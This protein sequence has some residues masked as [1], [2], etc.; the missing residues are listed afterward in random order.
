MK[1]TRSSAFCLFALF[2]SDAASVAAQP[3]RSA[4]TVMCSASAY[5]ND[6]DPKGTHVRSGADSKSAVVATIR[7]PDSQLDITGSSGDWLR[8]KN[9][10]S[11]DGTVSFKGEGWMFAS[12]TAVRARGAATLRA[13]PEKSSAI[14]GRLH[15]DDQLTVVGCHGAWL[16]V[17][18]KAI[19]GWIE[20]SSRCSNPVTTCS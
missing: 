5:T 14:A 7:D 10:R 16:R 9:V 20:K 13:T 3:G 1:P 15:D 2:A 11:V 17:K 8:V 12:L 19:T 18:H 6:P 4:T